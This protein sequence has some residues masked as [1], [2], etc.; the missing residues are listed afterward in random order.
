[1]KGTACLLTLGMFLLAAGGLLTDPACAQEPD[2]PPHGTV[3][4]TI[5]V[6]K[7]KV[8]TEG[9][10]S[11]KHVVV[12]LE[13]AGGSETSPPTEHVVM[14]Q[15]GLVFVPHLMA[16]Q[17]GTTVDFLNSDTEK[18]NVFCVE[19]CCKILEDTPGKKKA[20][21]MDLGD[22]GHGE[23]RT[24]TFDLA[25]VAV[26]LCKLHPEMA[27]YIVVLDTSIFTVAEIDGETQTATYTIENVPPGWYVLKTYNK[28]CESPEQEVTVEADTSTQADIELVRKKRRRRGR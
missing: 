7:T 22:W 14:D 24:Y 5:T 17:K 25:G 13:K 10:K 16:I 11:A 1:M 3:T 15:K 4:G 6:S 21:F 18:H 26:L 27:A 28:R 12:S 9:S 2:P 20:K 19:D 23:T 8:K